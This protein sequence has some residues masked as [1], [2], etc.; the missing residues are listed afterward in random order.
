[1]S[2]NLELNSNKG[3]SPFKMKNKDYEIVN[4]HKHPQQARNEAKKKIQTMTIY[5]LHNMYIKRMKRKVT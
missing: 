2:L 1:M 4:E 5:G 3:F